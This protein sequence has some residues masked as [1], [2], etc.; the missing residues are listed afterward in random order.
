MC[1]LLPL[2]LSPD[3]GQAVPAIQGLLGDLQLDKESTLE[4][5][6][7]DAKCE[8]YLWALC[9][10][11]A[12][13]DVRLCS[14]AAYILGTIAEHETGVARL[15]ALA[16]GHDSDSG[17]LLGMLSA[18][19]TWDD[20]EAVM[21]A[22]GTLASL[23]ET[24]P[25]RQWLLR[26]PK[27]EEVIEKLVVLLGSTDRQ[28]ASN[29]AL[30]LARLAITREGCRRLLSHPQ[31]EQLLRQLITCLEAE[32]AG[33]RMNAAFA[34]GRLCDMDLGPPRL[35][36]LP[37][38]TS[39][40]HALVSV[41]ASGDSGGS[42]NACF[43]LSCLAASREGHG[44]VMRSPAFPWAL[45]T[46]CHLLCAEEQES[47]WFAAMTMRVLASQRPGV[48]KLRQHPHLE[49]ALQQLSV[50]K[51]AGKELLEE[52]TVTLAKLQRPPKP[53]P[54]EAKVLDSGAIQV[55]WKGFRPRSE[56]EVHYRLYESGALLYR[57]PACHYI[58]ASSM[59]CP[60]YHFQ[61]CLEMEEDCG[62]C[63]D[64][65]VLRGEEPMP[66]CPLD[67]QVVGRTTTQLKLSWAPP[68]MP[69]GT[70]KHYMVYR[71]GTVVGTTSELGCIVGGLSPGMSY[72]LS[73]CACTS[74]AKG[75]K[76]WLHAKTLSVGGHAPERLTLVILGRS[77]ILVT[78]DVPKMPLGRF[79]NYELCLNGKVVYLGTQRSYVARRLTPNTEYTFTVSAITSEG[80]SVSRP[81]TKCTLRDEY[82]NISRCHYSFPWRSQLA[83]PSKTPD[84]RSQE[85]GKDRGD[86]KVS[87]KPSPAKTPGLPLKLSRR[88]SKIQEGESTLQPAGKARTDS[89][90]SFSTECSQ[91]IHMPVLTKGRQKDSTKHPNHPTAPFHI[92]TRQQEQRVLNTMS[93]HKQPAPQ[94]S[95][96]HGST[97]PGKTRKP[98]GPKL[99]MALPFTCSTWQGSCTPRAANPL[100]RP[101][102][103]QRRHRH[104]ESKQQELSC[105]HY[106]PLESRGQLRAPCGSEHLPGMTQT[107]FIQG[108]V[109]VL[110]EKQQLLGP[111]KTLAPRKGFMG[112]CAQRQP[113]PQARRFQPPSPAHQGDK[114]LHWK[115]NSKHR[116]PPCACQALDLKLSVKA[117]GI[118]TASPD[119][120]WQ[121]Q[122]RAQDDISAK[123][124]HQKCVPAPA[125]VQCPSLSSE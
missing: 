120:R 59:P 79:F 96:E 51:T 119:T 75:E 83:A 76:A 39:M 115:S 14:Y 81:V 73:V 91:D 77:E 111:W 48:V 100:P 49:R 6:L 23:A 124:W 3:P 72:R 112:G 44:H 70:I 65:T 37:E 47:S 43:A 107:R 2:L 25:G 102:L 116:G 64:T 40:V 18:M 62:P 82:G 52:V 21:N 46:L 50:S 28:T 92:D 98:L 13:P 90:L 42:R 54:P 11:L 109:P 58:L 101:A 106:S 118:P 125:L 5:F 88:A 66:S 17:V 123:G 69:N 45:D 19:L 110:T 63:S 31:A 122:S 99:A 30:V 34:L 27:A 93:S 20:G 55:S 87:P 89:S 35:L 74:T 33:C 68:A 95:R 29:S 32:E 7:G 4:A 104:T 10:L 60:K 57:G 15:V 1:S 86:V 84:I 103:L 80:R 9:K 105:R 8:E 16:E 94:T 24:G 71:E 113:P 108:C 67:F 53:L 117:T 26:D 97:S 56:L 121:Q 36:A 41:M 12:V 85:P 78:W 114:S 22:A 61:L 38:A